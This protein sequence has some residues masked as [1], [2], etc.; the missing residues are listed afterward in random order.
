MV[1]DDV[2]TSIHY[3]YNYLWLIRDSLIMSDSSKVWT[4]VEDKYYELAY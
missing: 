2:F 1:F 3:D 4:S